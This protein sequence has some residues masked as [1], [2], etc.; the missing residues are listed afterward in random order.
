MNCANF[1]IYLTSAVVLFAKKKAKNDMTILH[2]PSI[3]A[4]LTYKMTSKFTFD[5]IRPT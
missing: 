3:F 2:F 5:L 1:D 4:I